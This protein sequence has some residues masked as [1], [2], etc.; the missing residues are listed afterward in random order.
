MTYSTKNS[1]EQKPEGESVSPLEPE[2]VFADFSLHADAS[3]TFE[4]VSAAN[5]VQSS[6]VPAT[7]A[8][9]FSAYTLDESGSLARAG[10]IE[11]A[12]AKADSEVNTS[13]DKV[14]QSASNE[15]VSHFSSPGAMQP[16]LAL[17][18]PPASDGKV[19][20]GGL[21]VA[22][23]PG[24][25]GSEPGTSGF[26][27][28]EKTL[29]Y[30]IAS[31]CKTA[32]EEYSDVT[33]VMTRG[34]DEYVGLTER[35]DRAVAAGAKVFVSIHLNSFSGQAYGAEVWVPNGSSYNYQTHEVGAALGQKILDKLTALGLANRTVKTKDSTNGSIYPDGSVADYYTVIEAS[36]EAGIP[37]IIVEHAFLDNYEDYINYLSDE[38]KLQRLGRADAEGIAEQ[39]GLSKW[40]WNA[41]VSVQF[42]SASEVRL[43]VDG[44]N[45]PAG[46]QSVKL[47]VWGSP[48]G[49]NDLAWYTAGA[50]GLGNWIV[51]VPLSSHKEVGLYYADVWASAQGAT[52]YVG[53]AV[54]DVPKPSAKS[55][56]ENVDTNKGTFDVVVSDVKSD[57]GIAAVKVPVWS[58][59]SG[60]ADLIWYTATKQPNGT[61]RASINTRNH[62]AAVG[63]Y[64][65]DVYIVDAN[66]SSSYVNGSTTDMPVGN[67]T[68]SATTD[69]S[70]GVATVKATGPYLD[71]VEGVQF[72]V[73]SAAGGGAD[74]V[75]YSGIKASDGSWSAKVPL[76]QHRFTGDYY[77]HV[78]A[79]AG[80]I[81]RGIASSGFSVGKPSA[82]S[83][84]ENVDTNKGT[85]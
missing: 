65:A 41:K 46:L 13:E 2:T 4:V 17:K 10:S 29:N 56:I 52:K 45:A 1:K 8:S 78:Y 62:R 73:W 3:Y 49:Q 31:Y 40:S 39:Y 11:E 69:F 80:G 59:E 68:V 50:D 83:A 35:V 25:G 12:L 27:V 67:I 43:T 14:G 24:H 81:S 36:R 57:F 85:F 70:S 6:A 58:L 20:A 48:N 76:S 22:L 23:D 33:V 9:N 7:E 61:Y 32:L 66:G 60:G 77:V 28:L 26:G 5:A 72:P 55:A 75:W 84:I 82:K 44:T 54:F 79:N 64:F 42:T 74:L 37:G 18:S 34:Q 38:D 51:D 47:A 16:F 53:N 63:K 71:R 21:V 15:E 30:K 19:R